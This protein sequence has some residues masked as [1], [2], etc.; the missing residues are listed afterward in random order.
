MSLCSTCS[1]SLP[2][3][4]HIQQQ[5]HITPY[6]SRPICSTCLVRNPRLRTY[7]PCLGCLGGVGAVSGRGRREEEVWVLG[8]SDDDEEEEEEEEEEGEEEEKD[9][10]SEKDRQSEGKDNDRKPQEQDL[11]KANDTPNPQRALPPKDTPTPE[12]ANPDTHA[13]TE[14]LQPQRHLIL[15]TDTLLGL[16]IKYRV[17]GHALC[18]LNNLPPSTLRTT[19]HLLHTR[20]HLLLPPTISPL[21]PLSHA[22]PHPLLSPSSSS[23]LDT[24]ERKRE[25]AVKRFQLVTKEVDLDI[26]RA[27]VG[28]EED[29]DGRSLASSFGEREGKGKGSAD[30]GGRAGREGREARAV[31]RYVDDTLWEREERGQGRALRG[32]P[33]FEDRDRRERERAEGSGGWMSWFKGVKAKAG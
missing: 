4:P 6:C 28:L 16:A 24:P 17:D 14:P 18:R 33:W 23:A 8:G 21:S 22:H 31:E 7:D 9:S 10:Q 19:P 11:P 26:A 5:L 15:P 2:P 30:A 12:P 32:A 27:Y 29:S 1:S 13:S 25:R 20:T 3:S